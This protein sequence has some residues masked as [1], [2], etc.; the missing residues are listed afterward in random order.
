MYANREQEA[1][2]SVLRGLSYNLHI[3]EA[4]AFNRKDGIDKVNELLNPIISHLVKIAIVDEN[5]D[6]YVKHWQ[7][8]VLIW[9]DSI[10]YVCNNLK[11][12]TR[13]KYRDY[14]LCLNDDLGDV[15]CVKR[16]IRHFRIKW[17]RIPP[18]LMQYDLQELHKQIRAILEA[19]FLA[20]SQNSWDEQ[21]LITNKIYKGFI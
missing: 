11:N 10:D 18:K 21:T 8:E 7:H 2:M 5:R 12:K 3:L 9:L 17:G 16:H 19:Q 13:L 4:M 15:S 20:M 14:M 1:T 6:Y